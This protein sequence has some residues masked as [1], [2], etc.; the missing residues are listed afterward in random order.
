MNYPRPPRRLQRS[1]D[2]MIGGVCGGIADYLNMDPT[3]V[4]VLVVIIA[5][6][7]AAFPV[8]VIYLLLMMLLPEAK[9][10]P[11]SSLQAPPAQPSWN[12][13]AADPV[14]GAG[15]PPWAQQNATTPP[16]QPRPSAED[17]FSRARHGSK[18]SQPN[19]QPPKETQGGSGQD[20]NDSA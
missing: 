11:P 6:V 7:T 8:I 14:W 9:S 5:L 13:P 20:N 16:P 1:Q 2:R 3:L 10:I 18:P 12:R 17:L 19:A 4:R 15:G